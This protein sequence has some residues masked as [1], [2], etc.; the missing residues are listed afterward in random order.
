MS[1]H[2]NHF[3][4]PHCSDAPTCVVGCAASKISSTRTQVMRNS[5]EKELRHPPARQGP[6]EPL[7]CLGKC[8]GRSPKQAIVFPFFYLLFQGFIPRQPGAIPKSFLPP[9]CFPPGT[10]TLDASAMA[11]PSDTQALGF[12]GENEN[13]ERKL[14]DKGSYSLFP[15]VRK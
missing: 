3:H 10:K 2:R 7:M 1:L 9:T 12:F 14:G 8:R 13:P 6:W 15:T 4:L 5:A 11:T